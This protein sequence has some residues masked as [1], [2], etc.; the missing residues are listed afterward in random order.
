MNKPTE[1]RNEVAYRLGEEKGT[2]APKDLEGNIYRDSKNP[3]RIGSLKW[4]SWNEGFDDS[5]K[6]K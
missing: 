2:K 5:R 3:F 6:E 1:I 4:I